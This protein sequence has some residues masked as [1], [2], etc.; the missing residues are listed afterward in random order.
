MMIALIPSSKSVLH[1]DVE[2]HV[3]PYVVVVILGHYSLI[4]FVYP[5]LML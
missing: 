3:H 1:K 4:Y 2:L 5:I